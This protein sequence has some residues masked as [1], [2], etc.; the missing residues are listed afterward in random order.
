MELNKCACGCGKDVVPGRKWVKPHWRKGRKLSDR[1]RK[2]IGE[3]NAVKMKQFWID[4]PELKDEK[5][6]QL[7]DGRTSEVEA[8]RIAASTKTWR[9][10]KELQACAGERLRERW[11]EG[12]MNDTKVKATETMKANIA[13]GTS[14]LGSDQHREHVSNAITQMYLDGGF[15]WSRG[16][17]VSSKTS[18]KSYY[19]S[20]WELRH[21]RALDADQDVMTW[22]YEP[23]Y[24]DYEWERRTHKYLPDFVVEFSDGHCEIQ[25][26]GVKSVKQM[27]RQQVKQRAAED[28]CRNTGNTIFKVVSF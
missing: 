3:K 8:R 20:S 5:T 6:R 10:D 23:F 24:I 1:T 26:V 16:E 12:S 14:Y 9:E 27:A 19:R 21:M 7:Q 4:H 25:E 15:Q 28:Y 2:K 11:L 18:R 13:N 22:R 17:Y